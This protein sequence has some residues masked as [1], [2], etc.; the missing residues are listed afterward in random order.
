MMNSF[1]ITELDRRISNLIQVGTV[2]EAD[3]SKAKLKVKIGEIVTDWLPWLT[4]RASNDTTWWAPEVGE[5]VIVLA[6]SGELTQAVILPA[7]Y[8]NAHPAIDDNV[9]VS[10]TIYKD[11]TFTTYNRDSH[12]LTVDVNKDGKVEVIIGA[13]TITMTNTN[14]K[15]KNGSSSILITDSNITLASPRI[16][17][18]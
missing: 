17:F 13:S 14:I 11:G 16:D 4:K 6:P 15:L 18:N 10:K 1:E 9:D 5:Q 7:L 2:S 3:Y 8:Q 12:V